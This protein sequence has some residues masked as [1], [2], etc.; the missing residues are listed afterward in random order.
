M[1][2]TDQKRFIQ[3]PF[4]SEEEIESVV[5]ENSTDIF[6][7]DS[8]YF[9][10]TLIKTSGGTGTIPDGFVIDLAERRW[11]IVEAETS[12]HGVYEHIARQVAKQIVASKQP[13][14]RKKL[15]E[16]AVK[17]AQEDPDVNELFAE[18]K[19]PAINIRKVLGE[20]VEKDPIVG[21]PIDAVSKELEDWANT[22]NVKVRLWLI[23][24]Y[25]DIDNSKSVLYEIP[26]DGRPVLST[27]ESEKESKATIAQFDVSIFDLID[28][29]FIKTGEKLTMVYGPRNGDKKVYEGTI[30]RDGS[31][32][33][34][35]KTFSSLSFAAVHAI[36][37]AGSNRKTVNG[38]TSWRNSD[39][40]YLFEL[41]EKF[42]KEMKDFR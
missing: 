11:F 42:L 16:L 36:Q 21:M 22:L 10:K 4:D 8:I 24:K 26:D 37:N 19:I 41:R 40:E 2:V 23:K 7:P 20:I 35:G 27:I 9:P 12:K 15:I 6:G 39:G 17:R 5:V 3:V 31:V 33:V 18:A 25:V 34:L 14:T 1:L 13:E 32:T 30:G 29:G 28:A 38:W